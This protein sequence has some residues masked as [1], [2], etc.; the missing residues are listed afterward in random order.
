MRGHDAANTEEP[1]LAEI[2]EAAHEKQQQARPVKA[3]GGRKGNDD[4]NEP[5][6]DEFL[7]VSTVST[8]EMG[9]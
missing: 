4:A 5:Y 1:D 8:N 2:I 3:T 7:L 6:K 9:I